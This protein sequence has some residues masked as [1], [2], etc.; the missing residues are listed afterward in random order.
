MGINHLDGMPVNP[1]YV[2]LYDG[3]AVPENELKNE[4]YQRQQ[5]R[6]WRAGV[7]HGTLVFFNEDDVVFPMHGRAFITQSALTDARGNIVHPLPLQTQAMV[8]DFS[9][10]PGFAAGSLIVYALGPGA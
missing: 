5:V 8:D 9:S 7:S 1:I 10:T 3:E 2:S 4:G 6:T